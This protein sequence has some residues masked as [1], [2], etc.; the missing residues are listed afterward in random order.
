MEERTPTIRIGKE[1]EL[2]VEVSGW[3]RMHDN[4]KRQKPI[5]VKSTNCLALIYGSTFTNICLDSTIL[6]AFVEC[7]ISI[8]VLSKSWLVLG[9]DEIIL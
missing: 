1:E 3:N 5:W 6:K 4:L 2:C 7:K 8:V 9:L